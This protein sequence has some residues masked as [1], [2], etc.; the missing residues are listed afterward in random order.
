MLLLGISG[1]NSPGAFF[2]QPVVPATDPDF[3]GC[4]M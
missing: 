1:G 4:G 3:P 2:A